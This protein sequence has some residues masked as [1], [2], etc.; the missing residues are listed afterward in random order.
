MS[1]NNDN[2]KNYGKDK[3]NK[4]LFYLN[5]LS[6]YK[7][8]SDDPDVRGWKVKDSD[9][10]VIGKVDNLLVNKNTKR[11]VYLDVEVDKSIIEANHDPYGQPADSDVH[12]FINKEGENHI[13]IPVGL[14]RINDKDSNDKYVYTDRINHRTF[15]ET[16]RKERG[17]NVSRDYEVVVLES[18]NRDRDN[19]RVRNNDNDLGRTNSSDRRDNDSFAGTN[20]R[21]SDLNRDRDS[22][23]TGSGT[24][25]RDSDVNRNRDS[26]LSGSGTGRRDSDVNL[27]RDSSLS[28]SGTDRRDSDVNRNRDSSLSG[29]GSDRRDDDSFGLRGSEKREGGTIGT[30]GDNDSLSRDT[31]TDRD[32]NRNRD[33]E[34]DDSFYERKEFDRSNYR[35]NNS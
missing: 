15:A 5:E 3:N 21:D 34:D 28:G 30:K 23:L 26:S 18:Y 7:V 35:R 8:A 9:N 29:S 12:E 10:R 27:N 33:Y 4:H 22:S 16:K 6:D 25:R 31:S 19:D 24:D 1:S 11:V 20:R 2:N 13:I 32:R 17:A 14:V